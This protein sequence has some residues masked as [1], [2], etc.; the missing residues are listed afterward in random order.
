M[1]ILESKIAD[2]YYIGSTRDIEKRINEHNRRKRSW[3]N[4]F[5]PWK[6]TYAEEFSTRSDAVKR[7]RELKSKTGIKEKLMIIKKA[8]LAEHP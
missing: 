6:L 2:R 1:Y 3:T 4:R 7:E 5:R 8:G